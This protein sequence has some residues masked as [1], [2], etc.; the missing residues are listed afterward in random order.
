[1]STALAS[2]AGLSYQHWNGVVS[3][4]ISVLP[5]EFLAR[6]L[7]TVEIALYQLLKPEAA[8]LPKAEANPPSLHR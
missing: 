2:T 6:R 8:G 7:N 3:Q 1:M 5:V 4:N